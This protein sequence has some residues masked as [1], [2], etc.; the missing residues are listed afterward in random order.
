MYR[1]RAQSG[2]SEMELWLCQSISAHFRSKY[3]NQL[4]IFHAINIYCF[5]IVKNYKNKN[6]LN[7]TQRWRVLKAAVVTK[8]ISFIKHGTPLLKES[9]P[10]TIS[11]IFSTVHCT[12]LFYFLEGLGNTNYSIQQ[13][14]KEFIID[15]F[16]S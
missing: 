5:K 14:K 8:I 4:C 9:N 11:H 7:V 13:L 3:F 16:I 1:G 12:V 15:K 6:K 2:G 10:A